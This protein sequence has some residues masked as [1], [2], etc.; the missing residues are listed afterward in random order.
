MTHKFAGAISLPLSWGR[1]SPPTPFSVFRKP[2]LPRRNIKIYVF[3]GVSIGQG[4]YIDVLLS[5]G[6]EKDEKNLTF[7]VTAHFVRRISNYWSD[8]TLF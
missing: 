4:V 3:K 7:L 8:S 6:F 1:K 2:F 5:L